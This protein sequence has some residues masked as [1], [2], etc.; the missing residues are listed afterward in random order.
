[1]LEKKNVWDSKL[2]SVNQEKK[3]VK[4]LW[5]TQTKQTF[6][7]PMWLRHYLRHFSLRMCP[8]PVFG[9]TEPC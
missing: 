9:L 1:M 2:L 4:I 8:P 6:P 7:T 5:A 3:H